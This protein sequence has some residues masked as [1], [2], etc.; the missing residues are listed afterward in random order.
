MQ[1]VLADMVPQTYSTNNNDVKQVHRTNILNQTDNN[2]FPQE[3]NTI[4]SCCR[5]MQRTKPWKT[6]E[7]EIRLPRKS[8]SIVFKLVE[9]YS[10]SIY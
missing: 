2:L 9:S 3:R 8:S 7:D 5:W 10:R 1:T 6:L 4:H